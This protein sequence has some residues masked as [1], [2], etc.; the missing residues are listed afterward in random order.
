MND[1]ER[2]LVDGRGGDLCGIGVEVLAQGSY[3]RFGLLP[4]DGGDQV[5][6]ACG[7]RLAVKSADEGTADGVGDP[8]SVKS[9]DDLAQGSPKI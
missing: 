4:G 2:C 7:T 1:V 3:E 9:C 5:D 8:Q 6:V